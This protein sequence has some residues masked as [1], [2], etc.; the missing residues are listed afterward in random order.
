M[1]FGH[2]AKG[3][4]SEEQWSI[5]RD[6]EGKCTYTA[7]WVSDTG[8]SWIEGDSVFTQFETALEGRKFDFEVYRNPGG[9][10]ES[11]DEYCYIS[12]SAL[13]PFSVV[14]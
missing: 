8:K 3:T 6:K 5:S 13:L 10:P 14:D 11:L 7:P 1:L 12:D 4:L 2:T 9:A